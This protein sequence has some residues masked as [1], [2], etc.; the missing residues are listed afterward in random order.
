MIDV[1]V[2]GTPVAQGSMSAY[3]VAGRAVI[4]DQ[5]RA[6]LKPWRAAITA[7]LAGTGELLGEQP[8]EVR[9]GFVFARPKSVRRLLPSVRPDIDK[10]SR[11]AL[12]ALTESGCVKDD[13]QVVDLH[14]TKRYGAQPGVRIEVRVAGHN[15]EGTQ[16]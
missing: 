2:P 15:Q 10:T 6:V 12:D 14:V 8:V 7:A 9:L 11:A 16:W 5:K 3:V 1:W 4:T 13:A